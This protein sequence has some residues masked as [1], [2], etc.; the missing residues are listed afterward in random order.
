MGHATRVGN[1]ARARR[2]RETSLLTEDM[3]GSDGERRRAIKVLASSALLLHP[4]ITLAV[5]RSGSK[6]VVSSGYVTVHVTVFA[7]NQPQT[8]GNSTDTSMMDGRH[9]E[10]DRR[11]TL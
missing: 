10:H 2:D 7:L 5:R 1:Q 4:S 6:H 11:P 8:G 9:L 3:S